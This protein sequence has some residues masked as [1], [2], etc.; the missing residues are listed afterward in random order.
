MSAPKKVL[1]VL[2]SVDKF[3]D[4]TPTGFDLAEVAH[5]Y[6][7][8]TKAGLLIEF[9]SVTGTAAVD[10]ATVEL[11][12]TATD[13]VSLDFSRDEALMA[14]CS[15]PK[16]LAD[17]L[18]DEE[19]P[20]TASY[21]AVYLAGGH[22][23]VFDLPESEEVKTVIKSMFEAEK[24]VASCGEGSVG[25]VNVDLSDGSKLLADKECTGQTDEELAEGKKEAVE[26][27]AGFAGTCEAAMGLA[28]EGYEGE[29]KYGG[30]VFT[31]VAAGE[32]HVACAGKLITGQN[33]AS[34]DSLAT[35]VRART[36]VPSHL[37][38]SHPTHSHFQPRPG[39]L[40]PGRGAR[41]V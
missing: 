6:S 1:C 7:R 12:T 33:A 31:K 28:P 29:F 13:M 36:D 14:A 15:A 22:G 17:V 37:R 20:L 30:G 4:D 27:A 40:S 16:K 26:G 24:V 34:T 39:P 18:A 3:P 2:T 10:P 21:E 5:A 38:H 9:A 23:T 8:W 25:L 32:P 41:Q 19:A 35:T 11:A